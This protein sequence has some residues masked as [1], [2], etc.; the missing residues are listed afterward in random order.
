MTKK[1][2]SR[3]GIRSKRRSDGAGEGGSAS[4]DSGGG[5]AETSETS[6]DP[7]AR[8]PPP[9]ARQESHILIH[10]FIS[11]NKLALNRKRIPSQGLLRE[12]DLE[13]LD[14]DFR[15][16]FIPRQEEDVVEDNKGDNDLVSN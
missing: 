4:T 9:G 14:E 16:N 12:E 1:N 2:K 11:Y 3:A 13:Y 6:R 8:I 7:A 15:K 10:R 5:E